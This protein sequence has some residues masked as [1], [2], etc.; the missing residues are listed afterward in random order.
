[1]FFDNSDI[2][3]L[4]ARYLNAVDIMCLF[5]SGN[6]DVSERVKRYTIDF[7]LPSYDQS[8]YQNK[9]LK[10]YYN[11]DKFNSRILL[12]QFERIVT[13]DIPKDLTGIN[14][15]KTITSLKCYDFNCLL[16]NLLS[17]SLIRKYQHSL[18][19]ATKLLSLK[20]SDLPSE[21]PETITRLRIRN[22]GSKNISFEGYVL[23]A[24]TSLDVKFLN[25]DIAVKIPQN[26]KNLKIKLA[27][28]ITALEIPS[29]LDSL[30]L[31]SEN[32]PAISTKFLT[33]LDIRHLKNFRRYAVNDMIE[34]CV[35]LKT[36]KVNIFIEYKDFNE[37]LDLDKFPRSLTYL[38]LVTKDDTHVDNSLLEAIG[39]F[40][41]RLTTLK[42]KMFLIPSES[43][44]SALQILSAF[45]VIGETL[46]Q[47]LQKLFI[48]AELS[49]IIFPKTLRIIDAKHGVIRD[50]LPD[51]LESLDVKY[52]LKR[53]NLSSLK[54]L[55]RLSLAR[56]IKISDLESLQYVRFEK[57]TCIGKSTCQLVL[58]K[59]LIYIDAP[60]CKFNPI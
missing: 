53:M 50:P 29:S 38:E 40:P 33:K 15:P 58:P 46:P 23:P 28:R 35:S 11:L 34:D 31:A 59:N 49:N 27:G 17:L 12:E 1:M 18:I 48:G 30:I 56:C 13:L 3:Q 9:N 7:T 10:I 41:E 60:E 16:P 54:K 6:R 37:H 22:Y 43:L 51:N 21:L 24:L 2:Y 8:L 47:T 44:P 42:C 45:R 5:L 25:G 26:I 57:C 19:N 36:L 55:R 52:I 20:C 39:D 4:I 32:L 14:L